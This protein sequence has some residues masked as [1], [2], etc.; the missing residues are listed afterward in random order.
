MIPTTQLLD[1]ARLIQAAMDLPL[2][3]RADF[4]KSQRKVLVFLASVCG[5]DPDRDRT[6]FLCWPSNRNIADHT[7]LSIRTVADCVRELVLGDAIRIDREWRRREF[8]IGPELQRATIGA[9]YP[10]NAH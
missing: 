3:G 1:R 8:M 4:R 6:Y 9:A 7:G 2:E 10:S 5:I